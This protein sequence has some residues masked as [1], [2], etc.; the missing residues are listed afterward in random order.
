MIKGLIKNLRKKDNKTISKCISLVENQESSYL[1]LL[2]SIFPYSGNSYRIGITGPPGS[3]KSTLTDQLVKII[4]DKGLSVA[5]IAI[6]PSSPFNGGA[7]L[8]DRV[9]FINDFKKLIHLSK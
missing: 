7:I 1:E 8:G 4:L 3:G 2:S 5:I 6:D 9:R